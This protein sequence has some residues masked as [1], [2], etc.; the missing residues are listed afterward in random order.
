MSLHYFLSREKVKQAHGIGPSKIFIFLNKES[1]RGSGWRGR[2]HGR[3]G[4][5]N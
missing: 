1:T 3:G 5:S 4:K 2:S